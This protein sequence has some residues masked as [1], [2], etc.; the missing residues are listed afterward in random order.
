MCDV[1]VQPFSQRRGGEGGS[2][3]EV[4]LEECNPDAECA[5]HVMDVLGR[6]DAQG[7]AYMHSHVGSRFFMCWACFSD[8]VPNKQKHFWT[9]RLPMHAVKDPHQLRRAQGD[10]ETAPRFRGREAPSDHHSHGPAP[11]HGTGIRGQNATRIHLVPRPGRDHVSGSLEAAGR[12]GHATA[13]GGL[14]GPP[15][16]SREGPLEESGM[17]EGGPTPAAS[18]L[19]V[20]SC[21]YVRPGFRTSALC[22]VLFKGVSKPMAANH[23]LHGG[24]AH[25]TCHTGAFLPPWVGS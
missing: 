1:C 16:A 22:N 15:L 23:G 18:L 2:Q 8:V 17:A 21:S 4:S 20:C 3:A 7:R 11:I 12:G 6:L 24:G 14:P 25:A 5:W 19:E 9:H 10:T 13:P